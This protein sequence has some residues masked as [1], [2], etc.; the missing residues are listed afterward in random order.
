[1]HP[2]LGGS[3]AYY[4]VNLAHAYATKYYAGHPVLGS[5]IVLTFPFPNIMPAAYINTLPLLP[6]VQTRKQLARSSTLAPDCPNDEEATDLHAL[7][8]VDGPIDKP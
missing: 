5:M 2:K 7:A 3:R 6:Y 8:R 4:L 1:M